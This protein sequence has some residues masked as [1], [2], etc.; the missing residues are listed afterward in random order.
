MLPPA[1][2]ANF[3]Q[4]PAG[5]SWKISGYFASLA[6]SGIRLQQQ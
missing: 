6:T 1:R 3:E 2:I 5:R 4:L